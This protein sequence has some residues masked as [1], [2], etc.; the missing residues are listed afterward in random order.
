MLPKSV[1]LPGRN[2]ASLSPSALSYIT[3]KNE[4]SLIVCLAQTSIVSFVQSESPSTTHAG[5]SQN[6]S[7][8]LHLFVFSF[9]LAIAIWN[10]VHITNDFIYDNLITVVKVENVNE[11]FP[12]L[13]NIPMTLEITIFPIIFPEPWSRDLDYTSGLGGEFP[14]NTSEILDYSTLNQSLLDDRVNTALLFLQLQS[15]DNDVMACILAQHKK[16][17][18]QNYAN[19]FPIRSN[20]GKQDVSRISPSDRVESFERSDCRFFRYS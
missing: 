5:M 16:E 1:V 9:L 20:F 13:Q 3:R 4:T 14:T 7:A 6:V 15:M 11:T 19:V 10:I 2:V 18:M 12:F 17:K 8:V